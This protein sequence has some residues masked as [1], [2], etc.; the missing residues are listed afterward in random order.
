MG[1]RYH[2]NSRGPNDARP[3][4]PHSAVTVWNESPGRFTAFGGSSLA[5]VALPQLFEDATVAK[6]IQPDGIAVAVAETG[7]VAFWR[8][9]RPEL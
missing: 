5:P 2:F 7:V 9:L 3:I 4:D 1:D 6:Q 8:Y